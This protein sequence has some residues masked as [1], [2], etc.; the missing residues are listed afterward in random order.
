MTTQQA[1]QVDIFVEDADWLGQFD[2]LEVWRSR[3]LEAGPYEALLGDTWT[4]AHLPL[5]VLGAA[6]SP[7]Q[8]GPSLPLVGKTLLLR[9]NKETDIA[10]VFTGTDPLTLAQ[11][12]S[13]IQAGSV[14]LLFSYV[15]SARLIIETSLP[16]SGAVIEVTGGTAAPLLHLPTVDPS[17]V[18][19]GKDA[20]IPLVSGVSSYLF[21]DMNGSS[22]YFYK[23]RFYNA[24][25]QS[26]SAFGLPFTGGAPAAIGA[27][28]LV[29]GLIDIVDLHGVAMANQTVLLYSR[30]NG[31]Q[32]GGVVLAG[33]GARIKTDTAGRAEFLLVRGSEVTIALAGTN[34]VRDITVPT[35]PTVTS[36]N[37]LDPAY[38][39]DDLFKVQVPNVDYAVRRTL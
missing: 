17:N 20:R 1:L 8:T 31:V 18:A 38:G 2:S 10:Y 29:R 7:A 27:E 26:Y 12:A 19:Y 11:A 15:L 22:T 39:Q 25:T 9:V 37:L 16:G 13:Q 5:D 21:T 30:S 4:P 35:D 14:G 6:P 3:S 24:N 23:T 28:N 32:V 36:F 33:G 34:I